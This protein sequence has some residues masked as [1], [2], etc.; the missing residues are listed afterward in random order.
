MKKKYIVLSMVSLILLFVSCTKERSNIEDSYY[1]QY[2]VTSQGGGGATYSVKDIGNNLMASDFPVTHGP[3][4]KG[5]IAY[6]KW[7]TG[8]GTY[9]KAKISISKDGEPFVT[10]ATSTNY[11]YSGEL[12]Y[13]IN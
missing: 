2:T 8:S 4:K 10:K 12:S 9:S 13:T 6:I 1:V 3:V 7:S 11:S 5:Y